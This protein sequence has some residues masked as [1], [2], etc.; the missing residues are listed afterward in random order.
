MSKKNVIAISLLHSILKHSIFYGEAI[1]SPTPDW[2][3]SALRTVTQI[4]INS[5]KSNLGEACITEAIAKIYADQCFDHHDKLA[6]QD[7]VHV[8]FGNPNNAKVWF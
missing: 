4:L 1:Y 6:V 7:V 8:L 5:S 2:D 3:S